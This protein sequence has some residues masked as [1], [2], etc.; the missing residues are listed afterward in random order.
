MTHTDTSEKGPGT[1]DLH[2]AHG[3]AQRFRRWAGR[4]FKQF[5]DND[6]FRRWLTDI[7]FGLTYTSAAP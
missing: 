5:M 3:F 7:V 2:G 6:S 4:L 1:V